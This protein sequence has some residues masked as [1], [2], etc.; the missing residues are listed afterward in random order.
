MKSKIIYARLGV[1]VIRRKG[2]KLDEQE[3]VHEIE[4][5]Q[6]TLDEKEINTINR[7]KDIFLYSIIKNGYIISTT[8]SKRGL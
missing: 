5:E 6:E 4:R 8:F 3:R 2:E 1:N 7:N